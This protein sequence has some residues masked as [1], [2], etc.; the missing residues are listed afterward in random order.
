MDFYNP[1]LIDAKVQI[2]LQKMLLKNVKSE[3]KTILIQK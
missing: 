1:L 2:H 3:S